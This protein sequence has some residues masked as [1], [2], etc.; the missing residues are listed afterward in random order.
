MLGF[1]NKINYDDHDVV[2]MGNFPEFVQKVYMESKGEGPAGDPIL[3]PKQWIGGLYN[4]WI[5]NLLEI[6]HFGREKDLNACVKQ[7]LEWVHGFIF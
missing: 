7:L 4:T 6:P 5:M 1:V 3:E 2:Y